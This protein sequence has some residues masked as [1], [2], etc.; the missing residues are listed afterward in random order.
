MYLLTSFSKGFEEALYIRLTEH[1]NSNKLLVGNQFSFSKGVA[2]EEAS[3]KLTNGTLN[4]LNN[5]IMVGSIFCDLETAFNSVNHDIL[6]SKLPYR[7]IGGKA[8][9]LLESYLKIYIKEFKL[10]S[11][12]QIRSRRMDQ[13][14]IWG[15]AGFNLEPIVICSIHQ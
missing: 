12:V 1:F 15:A 6:L 3:F 8:T 13:N 10:S 2:T 9:L 5:K 14:W 7:G 4:T 11:C